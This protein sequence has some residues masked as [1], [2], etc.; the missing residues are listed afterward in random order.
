MFEK[1]LV[2]ISSEY[3]SKDVIKIT[4]FLAKI[5][6]STVHILNILEEN[7]L[8]QM[9]QCSDSHLTY[10]ERK[11]THQ[12]LIHKQKQTADTIILNDIQRQFLGKIGRAHV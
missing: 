3:Y 2:P 12:D 7:P 11:E 9:E 5:F 4:I 6:N 8:Q 10:H 1:I